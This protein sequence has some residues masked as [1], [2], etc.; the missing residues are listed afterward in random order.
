MKN[1]NMEDNEYLEYL[2][3]LEDMET[4]T[5]NNATRTINEIECAR[6]VRPICNLYDAYKFIQ[7]HGILCFL[8]NTL[9]HSIRIIFAWMSFGCIF[10]SFMFA[11]TNLNFMFAITNNVFITLIFFGIVFGVI[12][13]L[14]FGKYKI[15][16]LFNTIVFI[17]FFII[18]TIC[19]IKIND[20]RKRKGKN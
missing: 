8:K 14:M 13:N 17:I 16:K 5:M 9:I 11:T 3:Y 6:M 2:Q 10:L 20:D 1:I 15:H 19:M 12:S 4:Q 7:N 18:I